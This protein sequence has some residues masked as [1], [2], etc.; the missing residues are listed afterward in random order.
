[1][2]SSISCDRYQRQDVGRAGMAE[3]N[4]LGWPLTGAIHSTSQG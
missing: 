1:M 3:V 4:R 2:V